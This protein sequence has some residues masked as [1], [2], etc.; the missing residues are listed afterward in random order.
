MK[1]I[2]RSEKIVFILKSFNVILGGSFENPIFG[3]ILIALY[4][5]I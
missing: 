1:L 3:N 4:K 2:L 5:E